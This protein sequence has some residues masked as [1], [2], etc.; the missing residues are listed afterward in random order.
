MATRKRKLERSFKACSKVH[1]L[2][3]EEGPSEFEGK[4]MSHFIYRYL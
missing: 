4:A 1:G 2:E 3:V